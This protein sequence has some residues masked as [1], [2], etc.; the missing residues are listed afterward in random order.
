MT[1]TESPDPLP[2]SGAEID[3]LASALNHAL[4]SVTPRHADRQDP[5]HKKDDK[6]SS[7]EI[8][9]DDETLV[10]RGTG[11]EVSPARLSGRVALHLTESTPVKEITL[12]FRG[13]AKLPPLA[14]EP[15]V[16]G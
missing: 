6:H 3:L 2:D 7:I 13:K 15:S 14:N 11:A 4:Q 1:S 10:L 16:P 9:L 12:Q 8:I 5:P